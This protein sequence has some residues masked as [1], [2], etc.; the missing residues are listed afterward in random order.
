VLRPTK[1]FHDKS[2]CYVVYVKKTKFSAKNKAFDMTNFVFLHRPQKVSVYDE[3][4]QTHL[5][6][7]YVNAEFFV[8]FF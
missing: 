7:A 2:T 1:L 3:T 8:I 5:D 4:L 6:C